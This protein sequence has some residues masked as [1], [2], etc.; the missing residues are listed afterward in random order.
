MRRIIFR[1]LVACC[2]LSGGAVAAWSQSEAGPIKSSP[3]YAEVLLRKTEI[4]SDLEA[5]VA[6]YTETNPKIVDLRAE[7]RSL[8]KLLE[9]IYSVKPSETSKLTL[10]LGRLI[11]R[12]AALETELTRLSR[13]YTKDQNEVKRATKRIEI[14]DAAINDILK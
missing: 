9:R 1:A 14:F 3:A 4:Q 10:A 6:D 8:D 13:S 7:L 2:V 11:V 12:R 5:L